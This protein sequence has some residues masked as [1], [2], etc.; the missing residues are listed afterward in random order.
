MPGV[1]FVRL[2]WSWRADGNWGYGCLISDGE[3]DWMGTLIRI[4]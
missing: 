4:G 1:D 2:A 3:W